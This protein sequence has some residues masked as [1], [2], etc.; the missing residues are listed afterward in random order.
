MNKI[1]KG[2]KEKLGDLLYETFIRIDG[3]QFFTRSFDKNEV[4]K[5]VNEY[6]NIHCIK[7]K[8]INNIMNDISKI[9]DIVTPP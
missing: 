6:I 1:I 8:N 2:T 3:D 7:T 4:E 5:F 9:L